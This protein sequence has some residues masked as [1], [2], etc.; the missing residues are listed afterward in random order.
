MKIYKHV[1]RPVIRLQIVK[2]N[3]TT[4]YLTVSECTAQEALNELKELIRP[5]ADIFPSG[6]KTTINI[7]EAVGSKNGKGISF[8]FYGL[9]PN[10]TKNIITKYIEENE[11]TI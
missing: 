7:R 5:Y 8:S 2:A 6:R 4:E 9:T 3:H 10:E 11:N 1:P